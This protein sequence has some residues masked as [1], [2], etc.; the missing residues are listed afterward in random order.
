MEPEQSVT[1]LLLCAHD[2]TPTA[3]EDNDR[4]ETAGCE[5]ETDPQGLVS[6]LHIAAKKEMEH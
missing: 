3:R 4:K 2:K 5:I 6:H 1:E